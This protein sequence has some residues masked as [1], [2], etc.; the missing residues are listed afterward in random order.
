VKVRNAQTPEWEFE[1]EEVSA[2]VFRVTAV[3]AVGRKVEIT[4]E[5][6][7]ATLARCVLEASRLA[8][9]SDGRTIA[10]VTA[11]REP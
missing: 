2:G 10:R 6:P 9:G 7:D 3:D 1:V 4:G 5:D 11:D 8:E